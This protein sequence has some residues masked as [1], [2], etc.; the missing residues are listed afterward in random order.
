MEVYAAM[1]DSM[2]Q[3][4]GRIVDALKRNQQFENTLICFFQDNGGCA[5]GLGRQAKGKY[6]NRPD[7]PPFPPMDDDQLQMDMI[8]KQTRDGF[9]LI[10][11][12]GAMP[13]P[14]DTYIAYGRGW[15]NVSNTP[16]ASTNI[17]S[18]KGASRRL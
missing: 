7:R 2:D 12:P 3:G 9:P 17:G 18:T 13:G 14:P 15:A 5:E 4:I 11:G 6:T 1:V 10:E 16:F 8:P